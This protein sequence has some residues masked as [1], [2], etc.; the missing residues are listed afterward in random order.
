M[1]RNAAGFSPP[2]LAERDVHLW[3]VRVPGDEAVY[4]VILEQL[5]ESERRQA[6]RY[7]FERHR[8]AF[9][10]ARYFLRWVLSSYVG[11]QPSHVRFSYAQNGKPSLPEN[12][13]GR[14]HFN[15]S[16]S[17]GL[18]F[19]GVVLDAEIG[20]DVE[21]IRPIPED[22]EIARQFFSPEELLSLRALA[23]EERAGGFCRCWT[24]K[25]AFLK[26]TGEGLYGSLR[27]FAVSIAAETPPTF[28]HIH[29][30]ASAA[31]AWTLLDV[32][33]ELRFAAAVVLPAGNWRT[34][35]WKLE[36]FP[37]LLSSQSAGA[38][39]HELPSQKLCTVS[40]KH[41]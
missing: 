13:G 40:E 41:G 9:V 39:E 5:S 3:C 30:D 34:R 35:L 1:S 22:M 32:F 24:R 10:S 4:G 19:C 16:H 14:I 8:R 18:I 25:E 6:S 2:P 21:E 12:E 33:L 28:L 29:G 37:W 15:Q 38:K 11:G 31:R 7:R 27:D 26:A 36:R 23:P 17:A 20:V